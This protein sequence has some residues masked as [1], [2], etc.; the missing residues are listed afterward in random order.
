MQLSRSGASR[1]T[2]TF[3]IESGADTILLINDPGSRW[4]WNDD[5]GKKLN[6]RIWFPN[7][8]SG[9]YD[10][11]VGTYKKGNRPGAALTISEID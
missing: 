10:I 3:R 9:R 1:R 4:H 6:A 11:W 5:S 8:R 7:A 2:L